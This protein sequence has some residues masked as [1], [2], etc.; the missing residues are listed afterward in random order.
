LLDNCQKLLLD[1]I[2]IDLEEVFLELLQG[3]LHG[4][5][6]NNGE[7]IQPS[8]LLVN[9]YEDAGPVG[10]ELQLVFC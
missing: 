8:D 7:G 4:Y 10:G 1:N 2:I 6:I 9:L 5:L 3:F